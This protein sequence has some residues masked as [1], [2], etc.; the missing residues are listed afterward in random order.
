[1]TSSSVDSVSFGKRI[2][3]PLC[4]VAIAI[5]IVLLARV[6]V[7]KAAEHWTADW[8][9]ALFSTRY[10]TQHDK[11]ALV[12]ISDETLGKYPYRI[13]IDRGLLAELIRTVAKAKPAVIGLDFAF[14]RKTTPEADADLLASIKEAAASGV[15]VVLGS[16]DEHVAL[17]KSQLDHH[18]E[19][20]KTSGALVGHFYFERKTNA[21]GISD[22]VVRKLAEQ[23][24]RRTAQKT[25]A[26]VLAQAKRKDAAPR[27]SY[28]AWLL[29]PADGSQTFYELEASEVVGQPREV[30]EALLAALKDKIVLIGADLF[31]LDRHLTPMAIVDEAR[32]PG[33]KVHAQI[34]AQLTDDRWLRELS[35]FEEFLLLLAIAAVGYQ[36]SSRFSAGR[37]RKLLAAAGSGLFIFLGIVSFKFAWIL[38][39]FTTALA[40]W[41]SALSLGGN[42]DK[43]YSRCGAFLRFLTSKGGPGWRRFH[44]LGSLAISRYLR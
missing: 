5:G 15:Q 11:V 10:A 29:P 28:I 8:R 42:V 22:Q 16:I 4:V 33:V 26:E 18:R 6:G 3:G 1:M 9:T 20:I 30:K 37:Y 38:L 14:V 21:Y 35:P 2:F 17:P 32:V 23:I 7:I 27:T 36:L 31:D 43:L 12:L 39:P 40:A 24:G 13:P 44:R 34:V 25:F 19:F 41:L